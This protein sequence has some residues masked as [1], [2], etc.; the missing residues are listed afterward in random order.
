VDGGRKFRLEPCVWI[1]A[2]SSRN[3]E[4][5]KATE[6]IDTLIS[7]LTRPPYCLSIEPKNSNDVD[8]VRVEKVYLAVDMLRKHFPDVRFISEKV[9]KAFRILPIDFGTRALKAL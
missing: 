9:L 2:T 5:F 4:G 3:L 6:Q 8:Q 1:F 7:R